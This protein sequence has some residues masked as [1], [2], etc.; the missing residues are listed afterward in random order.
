MKSYKDLDVY[1]LSHALAGEVHKL[2]LENLP[3]S[4]MF[5][6]GN[7][8]CR[9]SKSIVATIVEGFGRKQYQQEYIKF[10]TYA[11]AST[12]ETQEHLG[13]LFETGSLK[14]RGLYESLL[15]RYEELGKKL[16]SLRSVIQK[17]LNK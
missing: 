13:L 5:E 16:N 15:R 4:E 17:D 11:L 7:Q 9:S 1:K 6:E 12:D 2:T 14:D 10:L 3:K 8:V